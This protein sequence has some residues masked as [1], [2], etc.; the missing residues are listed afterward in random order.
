MWP[1]SQAEG[2]LV[3][4]TDGTVGSAAPT[5]QG[6]GTSACPEGRVVGGR[7]PDR[8]RVVRAGVEQR[9]D[10]LGMANVR[11]AQARPAVCID[12]GDREGRSAAPR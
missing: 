3:V 6:A 1:L 10:D 5:E 9:A 8:R 7:P 2:A 4:P 11:R 12:G